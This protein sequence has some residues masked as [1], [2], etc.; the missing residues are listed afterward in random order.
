[1]LSRTNGL[2]GAALC[3]MISRKVDVAFLAG[4]V[5]VS[6]FAFRSHYLYDLDSVNFALGMQRFEPRT[7]QP[8]PP[9]YFLYV[10]L[11]RLL[12]L[13]FHDANLSLVILSILASC[14]TVALIYLLA[15]DWFGRNAARFAGLLFLFS[16]LAWFH[17]TVALTYSVEAFFS[18][19]LG[20][21]CWK[22][23]CGRSSYIVPAAITLGIAAGVR[24]SSCLFLA[25]LFFFA[26][27]RAKRKEA[28]LG[29]SVL[30]IVV[31][32][33]FFPMIA[34]AGG[35]DSYF[36]ALVSLWQ[37][38]P[39][40][41][42][43]LNSSPATSIGRAATIVFMYFLMFGAATPALLR[44]RRT[45]EAGHKEMKIFTAVWIVPA[46]CFFTFIFLKFVN[47]GYL[48]IM[49]PAASIWLG[50]SI[51]DWYENGAG[52]RALKIAAMASCAAINTAVFIAAPLYC[53]YRSV[54][55]FEAEL[56]S[57]VTALPQVASAG[58]TLIIG[59]DSHFLGY[60]HAGYYLPGY[61]TL[62]LPGVKLREGTRIFAMQSRDTRLLADLP[63]GP[64]TQFVFF[65]LPG[66]G[67]GY[68]E[69]L[70]EAMGKLPSESLRTV[71]ANGHDFVIGPISDLPLL[72]PR[73]A[74]TAKPAN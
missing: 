64:W 59:F 21:L 6:R 47:S 36:G 30:I 12:Y 52:A 35:V 43:V 14:G 19:L 45:T 9:G 71:S 51:A 5:A 20:Y 16:P 38:V 26:L 41:D 37:A 22:V 4:A 72:F 11:G 68:K 32:G 70:R 44:R 24:P 2:S 33:W 29:I 50:S 7:H 60:R 54:R 66:Q 65:P 15:E 62:E 69:H 34:A 63:A 28:L 39:A 74:A 8:H 56:Q 53:S 40:K 10:C 23:Y 42:T 67:A 48:L 58:N 46:L 61:L 1:M 25:S 31:C 13:L 17:G 18:A 3:H 27:G 55:Q 73:V 49:A 57:V